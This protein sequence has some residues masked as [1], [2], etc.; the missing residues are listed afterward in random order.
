[1]M[2][3]VYSTFQ[4]VLHVYYYEERF[5]EVSE[6]HPSLGKIQTFPNVPLAYV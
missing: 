4:V 2:I 3:S 6:T 1:M 5:R